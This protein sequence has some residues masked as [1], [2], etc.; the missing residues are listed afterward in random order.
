MPSYVDD[1]EITTEVI[2]LTNPKMLKNLEESIL[3]AYMDCLEKNK[4]R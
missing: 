2:Y 1:A 4:I 3:T